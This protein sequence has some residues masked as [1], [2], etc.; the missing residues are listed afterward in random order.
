M[1]KCYGT[2]IIFVMAQESASR[3][4]DKFMVR[5]P[6]GM[7]DEIAKAAKANNRS[8]NAEIVARLERSISD[9]P[10]IAKEDLPVFF[11][12]ALRRSLKQLVGNGFIRV[13]STP[14]DSSNSNQLSFDFDYK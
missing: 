12:Y 14:D 8:M 5:M 7:R 6:E 10:V 3:E 9:S 13:E 11:E 2:V 4:Q 1:P